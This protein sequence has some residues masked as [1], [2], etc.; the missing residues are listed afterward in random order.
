MNTGAWGSGGRSSESVTISRLLVVSSVIQVK[1]SV[2]L[3]QDWVM[4]EWGVSVFTALMFVSLLKPALKWLPYGP[5][6]PI[7]SPH[8][9]SVDM[10]T[11]AISGLWLF[12]ASCLISAQASFYSTSGHMVLMEVSTARK[13]LPVHVLSH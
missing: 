7:S 9:L 3:L 12:L 4:G 8:V 2:L 1:F 10:C 6:L 5:F 13:A 11:P